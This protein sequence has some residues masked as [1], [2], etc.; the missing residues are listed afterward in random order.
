VARRFADELGTSRALRAAAASFAALAFAGILFAVAFVSSPSAAF[1]AAPPGAPLLGRL[2]NIGAILAPQL[3]FV[4]GGLAALRALRRRRVT[5]VPA[6]EAAV[7]VRRAV[8]GVLAGAATMVCLGLMAVEFRPHLPGW[9]ATLGEAAAAA[10]L[11]AMAATLPSL[12]A[13][14]RVRPIAD[15]TGGDLFD[16]LGR[17]APTPLRGRPWRFAVVTAGIVAVAIALAGVA[18]SDPI[19]GAVRGLG[20]ALVCLL[21]FATLG[22]FLGLWSPGG[23]P[24]ALEPRRVTADG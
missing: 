10:G 16:D 12:L 4:C 22:R 3:A 17:W 19:D 20:D 9:W 21:G 13:A 6:A 2:A 11:L 7:I 14:L 23:S 18:G 24:A 15:G 1:G 8:L 5:V